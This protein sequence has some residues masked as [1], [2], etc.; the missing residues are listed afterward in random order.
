MATVFPAV[1]AMHKGCGSCF[2]C[3]CFRFHPE[4]GAA[5]EIASFCK[6]CK[7]PI[8]INGDTEKPAF[9]SGFFGGAPT[10]ARRSGGALIAMEAP[11]GAMRQRLCNSSPV[12]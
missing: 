2:L 6:P 3:G 8:K 4:A 12:N 10:V 1:V 11:F 9:R 7:K 5:A